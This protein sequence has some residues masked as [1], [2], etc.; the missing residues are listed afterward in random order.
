M[1]GDCSTTI[2]VSRL[3][4]AQV[5]IS[6]AFKLASFESVCEDK[7][8]YQIVKTKDFNNCKANPAWHATTSTVYTCDF[9]KANCGEFLKVTNLLD[10]QFTDGKK[11]NLFCFTAHCGD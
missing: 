3:P 10:N 4:H 7:P 11:Y 9:G 1:T 2:E 6:S 5:L 8:V